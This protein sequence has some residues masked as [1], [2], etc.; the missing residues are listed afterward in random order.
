[1]KFRYDI[2]ALRAL[3]VTAVVL[4]HYKVNFVPGGYVEVDIFFVISGY[5][6]TSIIMGSLAKGTFNIWDF[7]YDRAKRIIPGVLGLCFVLLVAGILF[8]G[9]GNLSLSWFNGDC[10][11][12]F[13]FEFPVL[14]SNRLFRSTKRHQMVPAHLEPFGGM[15]VLSGLSDP[16]HG[17]ACVREDT[18]LY[19]TNSWVSYAFVYFIVYLVFSGRSDCRLL[20]VP[21]ES[22]GVL[23]APAEGMGVARGRD[24]R[25]AIRE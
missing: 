13:L 25:L 19:R 21:S 10:R 9:T 23:L 5:L 3:A 1:M 6:M 2:N 12:P 7:Y 4:F 14:G 22:V 17:A 16:S 20:P 8:A 24:C 15:A 11:S 18:A